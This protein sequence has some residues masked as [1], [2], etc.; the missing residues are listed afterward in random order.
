ME[1]PMPLNGIRHPCP[2]G[3]HLV[4]PA[5]A[6]QGDVM[7]CDGCGLIQCSQCHTDVPSR[8]AMADHECD[9]EVRANIEEMRLATVPCP[10]CRIPTMRNGGCPQVR[11]SFAATF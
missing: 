2:C 7:S 6:Q 8:E 3:A 1:R 11:R 5:N 9:P 4:E 10:N